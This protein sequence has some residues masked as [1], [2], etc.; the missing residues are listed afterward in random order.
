MLE[1]FAAMHLLA[2]YVASFAAARTAGLRPALAFVLGISF[3]LSGYI[4]LVG[5][6][7]HFVVT[8]VV[9]AAA[10]VLRHGELAQRTGR[11]AMAVDRRFRD[12]RISTTPAFPS[13]WFYGMLLLGLA[14]AVAVICGRVAVRQLIWPIAAS[15]LGLALLLPS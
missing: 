2:G 4:L 12:R 9:L 5:R 15:L 10:V 1:V 6:G 7:W 13:I 14:A 8:L 3:M 11:L